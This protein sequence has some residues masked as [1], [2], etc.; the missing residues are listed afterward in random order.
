MSIRLA[1]HML[2]PVLVLGGG[3]HLLSP[4]GTASLRSAAAAFSGE[5]ALAPL[6]NRAA[7]IAS[8]LLPGVQRP[9]S[10]KAIASYQEAIARVDPRRINAC[11]PGL[12]VRSR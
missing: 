1:A 12:P 10:L 9:T 5:A 2:V 4:S 3:I 6:A 8:C 7:A 11:L